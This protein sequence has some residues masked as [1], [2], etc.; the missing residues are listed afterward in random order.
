[1]DHNSK[2]GL[3]NQCSNYQFM[4]QLRADLDAFLQRNYAVEASVVAISFTGQPKYNVI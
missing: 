3:L 1:M 4:P 2:M